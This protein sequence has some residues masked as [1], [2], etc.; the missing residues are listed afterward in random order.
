VAVDSHFM[1]GTGDGLSCSPE[2]E[3]H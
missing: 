3:L 1:H 2:G